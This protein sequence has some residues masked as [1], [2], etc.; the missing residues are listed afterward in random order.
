MQFEASK[1]ALMQSC[2]LCPK[3]SLGYSQ[4]MPKARSGAVHMDQGFPRAL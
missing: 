2:G 3:S 4:L 1:S